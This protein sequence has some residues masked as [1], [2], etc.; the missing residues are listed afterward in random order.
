LVAN[1]SEIETQFLRL[2]FSTQHTHPETE[3]HDQQLHP[4]PIFFGRLA[5]DSAL[6]SLNAELVDSRSYF[7][8]AEYVGPLIFLEYTPYPETNFHVLRLITNQL[9]T[10]QNYPSPI[11]AFRT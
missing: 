9:Q 3:I 1:S 10:L 6:R 4:H 11:G 7:C 8:P 2:C 5:I